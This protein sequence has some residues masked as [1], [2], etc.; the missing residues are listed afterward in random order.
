MSSGNLYIAEPE[1]NETTIA[2]KIIQLITAILIAGITFVSCEQNKLITVTVVDKQTRQPLDS[3]YIEIK[4]GKKGDYTKTNKSGY[5]NSAGKFETHMMI[6]C[7]FGCY[8]IFMEYSKS[9]YT[10]KKELNM[11]E[12]MVELER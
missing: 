5:T 3:V 12:G 11:T 7:S 6:G 10:R 2:G 4:A 9:G 1:R 8:D